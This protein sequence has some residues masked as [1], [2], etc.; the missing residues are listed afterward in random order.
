MPIY[1]AAAALVLA[2]SA[3]SVHAQAG[4]TPLSR[5]EREM[6][7]RIAERAKSLNGFRLDSSEFDLRIPLDGGEPEEIIGPTSHSLDALA[8][9]SAHVES[10]D[11]I[12]S[13]TEAFRHA[14]YDLRLED[15]AGNCVIIHQDVAIDSAFVKG[16][17][18]SERCRPL[19]MATVVRRA[20]RIA[21]LPL[22]AG[23][24]DD[25]WS[26]ALAA[27]GSADVYL[28]SV[29]INTT[30]ITMRVSYPVPLTSP[31]TIDSVSAGLGIGEKSWS[32]ARQSRAIRVDT[33]LVRGQEWRRNVVRFTIPIDSTFELPKSWPLFQVH[34][35]APV[36]PDNPSGL[37]WTYA[38]A[39]KGFFEKL[40]RPSAKSGD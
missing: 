24:L 9:G 17:R 23:R 40:P 7:A 11:S 32:V 18:S 14:R 29:V 21:R 10:R 33:T 37:A 35:R 20:R 26:V 39:R 30:S 38:H 2:A 1:I 4:S 16:T 5:L 25:H 27:T 34:V 31:V 19:Y 15:R 8:V 13:R 3:F 36:T 22:S 12:S 28:D 6:M